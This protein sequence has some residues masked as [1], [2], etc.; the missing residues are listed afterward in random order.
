MRAPVDGMKARTQMKTDRWGNGKQKRGNR[1]MGESECVHFFPDPNLGIDGRITLN[2]ISNE[3][4][5]E[6]ADWIQLA[7]D[8]NQ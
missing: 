8:R 7:Q 5:C 6:G 4:G 3:R 1:N 2:W